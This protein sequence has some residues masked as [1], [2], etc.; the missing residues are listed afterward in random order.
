MMRILQDSGVPVCSDQRG[1][2]EETRTITLD[3]ENAWMA[4]L[5]SGTALKILFPHLLH[6]PLVDREG[7]LIDYRFLWMFRNPHEQAKS[8]RKYGNHTFKWEEARRKFIRKTNKLMPTYFEAVGQMLKVSFDGFV[9]DPAVQAPFIC[10]ILEL[11]ELNCTWVKIRSPKSSGLPMGAL[12]VEHNRY[13]HEGLRSESK[14]FRKIIP[15]YQIP[16]EEQ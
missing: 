6:I 11:D 16:K 15:P 1:S 13:N 2:L 10:N 14:F 5:R 12:E 7:K 9:Q 4:D 3:K 8:Q